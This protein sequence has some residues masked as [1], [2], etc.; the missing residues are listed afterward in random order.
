VK[1]RGPI[2]KL[3]VFLAVSAAV[4]TY[5]AIVLG[6]ISFTSTNDYHAIFADV[7]GLKTDS[8]VRIAGVDVGTVDGVAIYRGD[9]IKVDF[10]VDKSV[11][12][13]AQTKATVRYKNL[14]GDRYLE[15]SGG[16]TKGNPLSPGATI[17]PS[18]TSPALDLDTLLNGFKPLFTGLD[19]TQIN[20]LSTEIIHVFQGESG[21]VSSLLTTV[22]ALTSTLADRDH[23]IGSVISNLDATLHTVST[24]GA[25][26]DAL[27]VQ[28]QQLI[29]GLSAHRDP[30][31]NAI[32]HINDLTSST[33]NLL[34]TVRP[35]LRDDVS[36]LGKVASA[37]AGGSDTLTYVLH[38]LPKAYQ[39][40]ARLGA[41]G[42]FFNFYL[43][44]S[45]FR[46]TTPNG[47]Y[48]TKPTLNP[49]PRCK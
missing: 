21:T 1:R 2:V 41:Y 36:Q 42:N 33:A 23:L 11:P 38:R 4:S 30:I 32:V 19:P 49:A 13:G 9:Q 37:L 39:V 5:L 10:S 47:V 46:I 18:R 6:N 14:I 44:S 12:L 48:Y 26:L 29:S 28:T 22:A 25:D 40:L 45:N 3:G 34:A 7:S 15:L 35:D 16:A 17:P 43:C 24:H 27:I 8:P 20:A 31:G